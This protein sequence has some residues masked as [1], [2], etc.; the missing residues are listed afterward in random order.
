MLLE[1][2]KPLKILLIISKMGKGG[3]QQVVLELANGLSKAGMLVEIMF[4]FR[5]PQDSSII[6][7]L[8]KNIHLY[9]PGMMFSLPSDHTG[10]LKKTIMFIWLPCW[11]FFKTIKGDFEKYNIIHANMFLASLFTNWVHFFQI[12][13]RK[14]K[15]QFVETFHSDFASLSVKFLE[16][17]VM[18]WLW[19]H[20]D[21]LVLEL[22]REDINYLANKLPSVRQKY[23]PFGISAAED[24]LS[25]EN[26]LPQVKNSHP[27][28]ILSVTRFHKE[29]RV[30]RLIES[31][32]KLKEIT[33][34]K[35]TYI[36]V[37]DGPE[38]QKMMSYAKSLGLE[39]N[40]LFPGYLDE[41]EIAWQDSAVFLAA[42]VEDLVGIAGLRSASFGIPVLSYRIDKFWEVNNDLFW[43][44][45]SPEQI[46]ERVKKLLIDNDFW[47]K[48]S[49]RSLTVFTENFSA[50]VM[51]RS[52]INLYQELSLCAQE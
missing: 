9:Y 21:T 36:L 10:L 49:K 43:N 8:D 16:S 19:M 37:G 2:N 33:E 30:A 13:F 5:T 42:G 41:K 28:V 7:S 44:S 15:T 1:K 26:K 27:P 45:R 50:D 12:L 35:F 38:R 11:A 22:R 18:L 20:L 31:V 14:R 52:Y 46:A 4:F 3:A 29:K 23:I 25:L 47:Q 48:E 51:V 6:N 24:W 32:A 39:K 34:I 40:I 17:K